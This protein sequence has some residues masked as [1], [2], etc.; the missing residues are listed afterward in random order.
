[1]A[2]GLTINQSDYPITEEVIDNLM[3]IV[4]VVAEDGKI[5]HGNKKAIKTYGYTYEELIKLSI[6]DLRNHEATEYSKEQLKKALNIG[7][8]FKTYH[9]KKDGSKFPVDVRSMYSNEE[10]KNMV[11]SII[12]DIS[13]MDKTIRYANAFSLSLD[14]FD[15]AIIG[16]TKDF[17]IS[18]WS[19]AAEKK[20]GYSKEEIIGKNIS[21]LVPKEKLR[22]CI[23]S[24]EMVKRCNVIENME[25]IRVDKYGNII[26]VSISIASI[27]DADNVFIGIVGVYKDITENKILAKRFEEYTQSCRIALEGGRFGI[28]DL[29]FSSD[30]LYHYNNWK[31]VLGYDEED[32]SDTNA[33]WKG[34]VHPEDSPE[35]QYK[36]SK[37]IEGEEFITE[38][39]FRCKNNEYKWL[40]TK[41]RIIEWTEDGKPLRMVGTNEDITDRKLIEQE[42]KER[43]KQLELLKVEAEE[44][45]KAKS[46]FLANM[47]HEIRTP[48][49]GILGVIQL[50]QST[51]ISLEQS[52]YIKLLKES[53]NTLLGILS[54]ILDSSKIESGTLRLNNEAF[55]LK[56]TIES[57]YNNLLIVGNSKGL[58]ISYYLDPNIDFEVIGDELKLKLILTNLLN[59][60]TK[61]TESGYVSF[62]IEKV[63]G[64]E[65]KEKIQFKVKDS[66]IGIEE[67]FKERIFEFFTQGDMSTKKK[68]VG[69]GLG[70]GICKQLSE[71]MNGN[72]WFESKVGQGTNFYFSCE[73]NRVNT[74]N[75]NT[76]VKKIEQNNSDKDKFILCVEDNTI[77]QTV[78]ESIVIRKGYK[79]L[80]AYNGK[81]A[82]EMLKS[83]RVDLI[84]MDI[85]MPE[86]NGFE[87]TKI[88]RGNENSGKHVPIIALTAYATHE[89]RE[90]CI[91]A[92]M[93]D[94][95]PKPIDTEKLY[96]ILESYLGR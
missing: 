31:E 89:N 56:E 46:L 26:D 65:N 7:I 39:R 96:N 79:Y 25:T 16:L 44:A 78:M 88:I 80:A 54:N 70:L 2:D 8:E 62:R 82:L 73:F 18:L 43:Y 87:T 85:Q 22:E 1:M 49:N 10:S 35:M 51:E 37:H 6:F 76:I 93:N 13:D 33:A 69:T 55:D 57:I 42:L 83:T 5:L 50:L 53:A 75:D 3:D 20:F 61:F 47:S 14:I 66:G 34:L 15:D 63:S 23:D 90:K 59:N 48:M 91:L 32:I 64:D 74:Q 29:N 30:E 72:L 68:Y 36:F 95:I 11:V 27:Y 92:G 86:L 77:N 19:K 67:G 28:W 52:K 94:Y 58:E 81:D 60:A 71:M 40:R 45:N 17:N 24:L 41:G 38:N 12:R 9:Y 84:L 21:M 4:L